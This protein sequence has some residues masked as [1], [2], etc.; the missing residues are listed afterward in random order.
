[1]R[2]SLIVPCFN[3]QDN[4]FPFARA[5]AEVFPDPSDYEIVFV[6]DGS[7]D[8]TLQNLKEL[9]RQSQQNIRVV[10]FSRNFGKE[11]AIYAGLQHC[12]GEYISLI[13]ADLQQDPAIVKQMTE[14]LDAE[15][16]TDCVCAFQETR[17]ENKLMT[18]VK[19]AFYKMATNMS[20][21][22]FVDGASDFRTFR[23]TVR[24]ALL[25]MPE[26]FRFSKGLFSWVGFNTKYIPYEAKERASG[27]TKWGFKKL[28]KYGWNG[29]LAF[30]TA[31]L[32]LAT[33]LGLLSTA[34]S[35]IYF[36]VTLIR[37]ATEHIAVDGFTQTV[38]LIVF[39]GGMQL[40]T[41]GIIG[42]Y[43]AKNYIETKRRPV[44]LAKEFSITKNNGETKESGKRIHFVRRRILL[45]LFNQTEY[46]AACRE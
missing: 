40:F 18:S 27:T 39:F 15:P 19:S 13:D 44:Y 4:I 17:H 7:K 21:V 46:M 2:L 30:S 33:V 9:H 8:K 26:Y 23:R 25:Q 41:I 5:V 29:I 37:K 14:I 6:N 31:P 35:I 42:E 16:D 10:S 38:I 34:F 43:L 3:E 24:D 32:K 36:I 28:L 45:N 11:S 12:D 1:M 20:E 22:D